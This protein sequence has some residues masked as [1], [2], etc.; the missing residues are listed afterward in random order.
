M[1]CSQA[2]T[3]AGSITAARSTPPPVHFNGTCVRG[4][5]PPGG[6]GIRSDFSAPRWSSPALWAPQPG[7]PDC[8]ALDQK[9]ARPHTWG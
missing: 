3:S 9:A 2:N 7:C 4:G 5:L 1:P 6:H 8:R